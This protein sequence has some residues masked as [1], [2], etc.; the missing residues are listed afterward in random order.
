MYDY[1]RF[2]TGKKLDIVMTSMKE[3]MK[4]MVFYKNFVMLALEEPV[5][6]LS[7]RLTGQSVEHQRGDLTNA[8]GEFYNKGG[9]STKLPMVVLAI[10][11]VHFYEGLVFREVDKA[12][13]SVKKYI[14]I[15]GISSVNMSNPGDFFRIL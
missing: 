10:C 4:Q 15:Q 2:W 5:F 8:F 13:D 6:R 3:T 11:F 14:S 7:M 12:R 9:A 1:C